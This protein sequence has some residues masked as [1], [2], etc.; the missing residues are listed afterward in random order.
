MFLDQQAREIEVL[1]SQME[2]SNK[3]VE[4]LSQLVKEQSEVDIAKANEVNRLRSNLHEIQSKHEETS[5]KLQDAME[6][7]SKVSARNI[8][9]KLKRRDVTNEKLKEMTTLQQVEIEKKETDLQA[10]AKTYMDIIDRKNKTIQRLN[11]RLDSALEAKTKAQKLKSYYKS[12]A[13]CQKTEGPLFSKIS[14][15]KSHIAELEKE[16]EVLQEH[17][18]DFLKPPMVKTF[19]NGKYTDEV[20]AVYEDV[21]CWGVGVENVQKVVRTVIENLAGLEC[22][23]LPK[24]TFVR[25]MYLEA[26]RLSQIQVAEQL[27]IQVTTPCIVMVL[28]SMVTTMPHLM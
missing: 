7:L 19:Q 15:L 26:R 24:A 6:K 9:K 21:L 18:Q 17:I 20:R 12:K 14:E 27:V 11:E 16:V 2:H 3:E 10:Q 28:L 22:E 4:M 1:L 23:R 13:V 5:K 25:Y 8:N